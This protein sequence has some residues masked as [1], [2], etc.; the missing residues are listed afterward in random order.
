MSKAKLDKLMQ[1][2]TPK[3]QPAPAVKPIDL[4]NSKPVKPN[5]PSGFSNKGKKYIK[6]GTK[7]ERFSFEITPELKA[8]LEQ[9]IIGYRKETGK[10][11]SNSEV[12]RKALEQYLKR[13]KL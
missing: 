13:G 11:K 9:S 7:T 12:I 2:R 10:N 1:T 5:A 3:S 4:T 6:R 8:Q